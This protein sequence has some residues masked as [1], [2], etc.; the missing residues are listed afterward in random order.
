MSFSIITKNSE[1]TF[2]DKNFVSISSKQGSEC[3]VNTGFDFLLVVQY[4]A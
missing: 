4:D 1:Q 3:F 2:A